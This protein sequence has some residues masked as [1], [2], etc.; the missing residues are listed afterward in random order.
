[1]TVKDIDEM[2]TLKD[3]AKLA[4]VDVSTVSRAL[5][6]K[7]YVH[8]ET[9][10]RIMAAVAELSYQPN[11]LAKG[12]RQGKRNTIGVVVPKLSFS[13]FAEVV[14]G[15][16]QEAS[17]RGYATII[18]N[19]GDQKEEEKNCLNRLRNGFIDGLVI[20]GCGSN[21]RLIREIS[22][23]GM[24]V[25]Q[26]IRELDP[27]LSS[28]VVDYVDI[29]YRSVKYLADLGC[30]SIG[31]INGSMEIPPYADRYKGYH[32]AMSELHLEE[33]SVDLPSTERGMRYGYDC[34]NRLIDETSHLDAILA[35]T[36]A[37]GMGVL[38][39]A[40]ENH[41]GVPQDLRVLSMTG[42]Q[43]GD[44]LETSL[45]SMEL[46]GYEIGNR[47]TEMIIHM[48]EAGKKKKIPVQHLSFNAALTERESTQ[49]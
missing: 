18:C 45:T 49:F 43:V 30:R 33:L 14:S 40:K 25:V 32:M 37:Q 44:M 29:G 31:L 9:R 23:D 2:S 47:A 13:I 41:I 38:R 28:I 16:E 12:L 20:A 24:P 21:K 46:P 17:K 1:M 10:K 8:P 42:H 3:V 7:S 11:V 19:T 34:A 15:I 4:N 26:V 36:D 22:A 35:A 39:A 48:I 27:L 5:N 6:Q